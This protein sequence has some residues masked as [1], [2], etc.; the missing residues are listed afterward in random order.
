MQ[1]EKRQ[2]TLVAGKN[3]CTVC[4]Y[5]VRLSIA[6]NSY[7]QSINGDY[8]HLKAVLKAAITGKF[9]Q[10]IN[11]C[12]HHVTSCEETEEQRLKNSAVW[13]SVQQVERC[14]TEYQVYVYL[15]K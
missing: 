14:I 5:S 7:F 8:L 10:K 3:F 13:P 12:S 11:Q 15:R 1:N 6:L 2:I 9:S 4:K